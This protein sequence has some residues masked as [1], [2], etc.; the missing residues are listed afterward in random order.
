MLKFNIQQDLTLSLCR[1][2]YVEENLRT[3]FK[4]PGSL[5][6]WSTIARSWVQIPN[7]GKLYGDVTPCCG[8][9]FQSASDLCGNH[10]TSAPILRILHL[11]VSGPV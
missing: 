4:I 5:G 9:N 7:P 6:V 11:A 8:W 3:A 10:E 2:E 1:N